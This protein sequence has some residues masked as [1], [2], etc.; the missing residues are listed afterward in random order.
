[1]YKKSINLV[2]AQQLRVDLA[3][4]SNIDEVMMMMSMTMMIVMVM[5]MMA[6]MI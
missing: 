2:R 1:M 3:S 6:M 5:L 4:Q